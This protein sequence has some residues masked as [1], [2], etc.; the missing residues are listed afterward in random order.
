MPFD[1]VSEDEM[2]VKSKKATE[3]KVVDTKKADIVVTKK[4][5]ISIVSG[6]EEK[7]IEK[8]EKK[9]I[10]PQ[11]NPNI[12]VK[13][14]YFPGDTYSKKENQKEFKNI[15]AKYGLSWYRPMMRTYT[16]KE[17][18]SVLTGMYVTDDQNKKVFCIYE[19][20]NKPTTSIVKIMGSGGNFL[21]DLI[22]FAHRIGCIIE[23][24]DELFVNNTLLTLQ[25]KGDIY[26][27]K[28]LETG[29]FEDYEKIFEEKVKK[30]VDEYTQKYIDAYKDTLESRGISLETA[31]FFKKKEIEETVR[32]SLENGLVKVW[33]KW[34]NENM[35]ETFYEIKN[36]ICCKCGR[37][38]DYKFIQYKYYDKTSV[39]DGR[40]YQCRKCYRS[41]IETLPDSHS[42]II[43][44]LAKSRLGYLDR[45]VNYGKGI[46]GQ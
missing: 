44:S 32:W 34:K 22:S 2:A 27:E 15:L 37:T 46:I 3:K 31:L 6:D 29:K 1:L 43:K 36:R 30:L 20:T 17:G 26:V 41:A 45:Y 16:S 23:D 4:I 10:P 11:I 13:R 19:G 12:I 25:E 33:K 14:I 9:V 40:S 21:I 28:K 5:G 8:T 42:N 35:S 7:V 18:V 24:K 39:W 38:G